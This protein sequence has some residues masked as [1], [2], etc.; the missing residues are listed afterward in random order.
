MDGVCSLLCTSL[1]PVCPRLAPSARVPSAVLF[2]GS[3][4][5]APRALPRS[6]CHNVLRIRGPATLDCSGIVG[7]ACKGAYVRLP[8]PATLDCACKGRRTLTQKIKRRS[9]RRRCLRLAAGIAGRCRRQLPLKIFA[10]DG[11]VDGRGN[12]SDG[13]KFGPGYGGCCRRTSCCRRTRRSG[14]VG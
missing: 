1:S 2:A 9:R 12:I 7:S 13:P 11:A 3:P 10:G 8:G 5:G 4:P 14:T 6:R